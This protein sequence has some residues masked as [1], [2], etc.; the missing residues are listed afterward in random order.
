MAIFTICPS[1]PMTRDKEIAFNAGS[2]R[3][4]VRLAWDDFVRLVEPKIVQ[5]RGRQLPFRRGIE[6]DDARHS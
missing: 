2:H 6:P 3:G 1:S 4:L 5:V